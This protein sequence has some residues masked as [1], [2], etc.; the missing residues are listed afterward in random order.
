MI[1]IIDYGVGNLYSLSRS[2][3]YIGEK[4]AV[5]ND[6]RIILNADR[7]ILPG[8][9]AFGEA[10]EKLEKLSLVPVIKEVAKNKTPLLGICLGM[11]LLFEE[12]LEFGRYKGL[13]FIPGV[14]SPLAEDVSNLKIPHMGWNKLD[15]AKDDF[16]FSKLKDKTSAFV[17]FVHSFYAKNCLPDTLATSFYGVDVTAAVKKGNVYGTQFHPEKSGDTGLAILKAFCEVEVES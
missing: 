9:G 16:V 4:A 7:V 15:I 17:Y 8:V 10:M 14:V 11:Q 1:A 13:G 6:R 2:L 12:S 3:E 5:T